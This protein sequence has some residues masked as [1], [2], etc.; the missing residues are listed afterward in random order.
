MAKMV[1]IRIGEKLYPSAITNY[2]LSVGHKL[3]LID[4]S[5]LKDVLEADSALT[6]VYLAAIGPN[7]N[8]DFSFDEFLFLYKTDQEEL[9]Q[10]YTA[11]I[12]ACLDVVPNKFAEGLKKSTNTNVG[13]D[14]KKIKYPR[15][16]IECVED[17]YVLYCLAS[18]IDSDTFWHHPIPDL[19]RIYESR[20]AY[21]AWDNNPKTY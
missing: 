10:N 9:E 5:N 1:F 13:K 21:K 18:G 4:G 6:V 12:D 8:I 3:G 14:Q 17:R 19:E 7:K 16:E 20:Q 11:I 2:S 15:L